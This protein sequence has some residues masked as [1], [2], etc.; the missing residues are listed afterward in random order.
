MD[1]SVHIVERKPD[2]RSAKERGEDESND[3]VR[4]RHDKVM[5]VRIEQ[6]TG[7]TDE[8]VDKVK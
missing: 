5:C 3:K 6:L 2:Q 4:M 8:Q 1:I 7:K